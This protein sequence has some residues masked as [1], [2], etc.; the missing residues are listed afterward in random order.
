MPVAKRPSTYAP[1]AGLFAIPALGYPV[2]VRALLSSL[3]GIRLT[4]A[5]AVGQL[6]DAEH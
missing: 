3:A 6:A 4:H 5:I 2:R 1:S